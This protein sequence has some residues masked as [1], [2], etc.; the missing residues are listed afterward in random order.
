MEGGRHVCGEK[1][2]RGTGSGKRRRVGESPGA[3]GEGNST[4]GLWADWGHIIVSP[5][6]NTDL[7]CDL[8]IFAKRASQVTLLPGLLSSRLHVYPGALVWWL[9]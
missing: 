1:L 9:C 7:L 4:W 8:P 3:L 2:E 6:Q 5:K